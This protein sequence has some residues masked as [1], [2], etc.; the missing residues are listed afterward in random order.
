VQPIAVP[1]PRLAEPVGDRGDE[2]AG[3]ADDDERP[4]PAELRADRA[5]ER[6]PNPK[7]MMPMICWTENAVPRCSV[8]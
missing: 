4:V 6:M 2:E 1:T 5:A 8:G 7:P 3:R